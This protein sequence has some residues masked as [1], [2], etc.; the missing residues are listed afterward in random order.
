M[1]VR[2]EWAVSKQGRCTLCALHEH[3][4][5]AVRARGQTA[6]PAQQ[7]PLQGALSPH[8][9]SPVALVGHWLAV[10]NNAVKLLQV[11]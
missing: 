5:N 6:S 4:D 1:W 10:V 2:R 7:A 8:R 3:N 11:E 9:R